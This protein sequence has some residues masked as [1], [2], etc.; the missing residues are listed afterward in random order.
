MLD[1]NVKDA[2]ECT[3][4]PTRAII[5]W[6]QCIYSYGMK[7]GSISLT[8]LGHEMVTNVGLTVD[9]RASLALLANILHIRLFE[10]EVIFQNPDSFGISME[11]ICTWKLYIC[12]VD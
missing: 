10:V 7:F 12:Y 9:S 5:S 6:P 3:V 2:L 11:W 8:T 4:K 1:N